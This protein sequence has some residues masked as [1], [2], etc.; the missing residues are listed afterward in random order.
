MIA[1]G[2]PRGSVASQ[3]KSLGFVKYVGIGVVFA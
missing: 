2:K 3:N 1:I